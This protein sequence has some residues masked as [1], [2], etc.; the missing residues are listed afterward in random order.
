MSAM[1]AFKCPRFPVSSHSIVALAA[2]L[3]V[4]GCSSPNGPTGQ[5]APDD[6]GRTTAGVGTEGKTVTLIVDYGD[7]TERR[8]TAIPCEKEMTALDAMNAAKAHPRGIEFEYTGSGET[9]LLTQ[10]DGLAN[11][12]GKGLNWIFRVNDRLGDR[13]FAEYRVESGDTLLW[14]FDKYE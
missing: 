7:G 10:I 11:E 6:A 13:S 5:S 14:R 4:A 9:A 2:L 12:G 3:L 1:Y 8:F